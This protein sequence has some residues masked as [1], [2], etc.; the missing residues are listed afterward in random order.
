MTTPDDDADV[1][2]PP[3]VLLPGGRV[4]MRVDP[5]RGRHLVAAVD[6]RAGD[7]ALVARPY[8]CALH[9]SQR[10]ARCDHTFKRAD[11]GGALLRCAR[12]KHARY[13]GRDAQAAASGWS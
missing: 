1:V 12:C 11:D 7:E 9:D 6:M 10:T 2:A 13:L 5:A 3:P 4:E 8:A